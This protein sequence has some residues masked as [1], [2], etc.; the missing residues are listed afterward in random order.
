MVAIFYILGDAPDL[1]LT[2]LVV[3]TLTLVIFLLVL[4]KLPAYYGVVDRVRGLRD[5]ALSL[6]VGG[7]V[8]L[9]VLLSTSAT[10][11]NPI[12]PYFIEE[13]VPQGGGG[14]VVN[15]IL[16]DFRGFDTMGE[17]SVV[18]MAALSVLTLVAMRERGETQ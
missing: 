17:I 3:E 16:V 14:N 1:A 9:T 18:G 4:D 8:A 7:T 13:A 15:V 2:Q 10:P 6:L 5:A 11:E 12:T